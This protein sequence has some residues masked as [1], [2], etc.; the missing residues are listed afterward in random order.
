[1]DSEEIR[2]GIVKFMPYSFTKVGEFSEQIMNEERRPVYTTP[3]SFLELI[4]LFK[5]MLATK[6]GELEAQ[7]DQYETGVIKLTATGED[8]AKLEE[9]LK[10]F[11]VVVEEKAKA[12]DEKAEVVGVEK[13]KV[14][15]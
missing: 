9:E 11:A 3:K 15:I 4:K 5:T 1:M 7:R 12:A 13:A 10:I 6:K 14:E 2:A 8:V